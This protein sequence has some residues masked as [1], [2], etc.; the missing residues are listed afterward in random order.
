MYAEVLIEYGVKSL[1][2]TFTYIIPKHLKTELKVGMKVLI[3]FATKTINGFVINIKDEFNE[4]FEIKEIINIVDKELMLD[5]ELLKMGKHLQE[6]TL[7]SLIAAY[8]T[9]LPSSLKVKDK[10]HNYDLFETYIISNASEEEINEY[11]S[12]N[13]RSKKQIEILFRT[14]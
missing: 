12:N 2:K 8:K 3:P 11:I 9:M 4:D 13:P 14:L 10:K 6:K 7:C 5:D 1:D